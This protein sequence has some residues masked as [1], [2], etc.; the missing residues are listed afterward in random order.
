M[1]KKSLIQLVVAFGLLAIVL[2]F[3]G[4]N[5][6]PRI[7]A[8]SSDNGN[9]VDNARLARPNYVNEGYQRSIMIQQ[10]YF[11]SDWIERH[12]VSVSQLASYINSDWIER[13]PSNY[14]NNS[15]W[16]ERHPTSLNK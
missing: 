12:P 11:G 7:Y 4:V 1:S 14:Y 5:Y 10:S 9:V 2:I 6:V 13:H 15:D 8:L 3:L 16:I